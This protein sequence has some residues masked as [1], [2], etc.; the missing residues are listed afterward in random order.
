MDE[1]VNSK[2]LLCQGLIMVQARILLSS[3]GSRILEQGG[4]GRFEWRVAA[5]KSEGIS[6]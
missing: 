1:R 6:S 2:R 3:I 5:F 4:V